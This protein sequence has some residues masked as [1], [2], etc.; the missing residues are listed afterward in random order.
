MGKRKLKSVAFIAALICCASLGVRADEK[1]VQ[2][3]SQ[4]QVEETL[5]QYVLKMGL[6]KP[7]QVEV[8]ALGFKPVTLRPGKL[9]LRILKPVKGIGPGVQTFLLSAEVAS[10]EESQIWVRTEIRVYENVVVAARPFAHR[11]V[12]APEDV[13]L[14]WREISSFSPR[15]FTKIEDVVG[16]QVSRPT[17]VNEV[18]TPASA[19]LPQVV[20]HGSAVVLVYESAHVRV[21]TA[22]EAVQAG[23]VGDM[24]R[25]KNPASGKMLQGVVLDGRTVKVSQ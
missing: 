20:R 10:K 11:E 8:R 21:E 4:E 13:R 23:K 25:V 24:I 6:W 14:D 7:G 9:A 16:K 5:R 18:L 12:I 15:P 1:T 2:V 17:N 22:G 3:V 19:E